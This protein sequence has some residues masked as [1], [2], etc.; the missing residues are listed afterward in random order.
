MFGSMKPARLLKAKTVRSITS[1]TECN[2]STNVLAI[3]FS[4][5]NSGW[6]CSS[7]DVVHARDGIVSF[8]SKL[9]HSMALEYNKPG[10]EHSR[11][12][13][14]L[15]HSTLALEHSTLALEH[16]TLALEHSK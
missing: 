11:L 9:A 12:A 6:W 13:R 14:A 3:R 5:S 15:E 16:S 2:A 8:C 10:L 4:G 1:G 7:A